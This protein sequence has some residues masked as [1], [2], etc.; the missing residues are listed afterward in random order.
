MNINKLKVYNFKKNMEYRKLEKLSISEK[1]NSQRKKYRISYTVNISKET[2]WNKNSKIFKKTTRR[3]VENQ[4][5][6][7]KMAEAWSK[8]D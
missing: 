5:T 7:K 1:S 2:F 6:A 4:Q 8:L 3:L